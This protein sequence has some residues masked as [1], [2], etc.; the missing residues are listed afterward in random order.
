MLNQCYHEW[1]DVFLTSFLQSYNGSKLA[2]FSNIW[3]DMLKFAEKTWD[4]KSFNMQNLQLCLLGISKPEAF[5]TDAKFIP[6]IEEL[7]PFYLEW[8]KETMQTYDHINNYIAFAASIAGAPLLKRGLPNIAN[9]L[10]NIT[11]RQI[12]ETTVLAAQLCKKIWNDHRNM[13]SAD[14]EFEDAFLR[15]LS[16]AISLGS[17]EALDLQNTINMS[18]TQSM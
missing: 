12:D 17:R 13:M 16:K 11:L 8:A 15:I 6:I 2:Q 4:V 18:N 10:E 14:H 1:V 7:M 5:W 3:K 9:I